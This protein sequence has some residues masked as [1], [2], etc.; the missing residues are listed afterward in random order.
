[1]RVSLPSTARRC[2]FRMA[3]TTCM[4]SC[5]LAEFCC[6]SAASAWAMASAASPVSLFGGIEVSVAGR[7]AGGLA[8]VA[9]YA[10]CAVDG[11]CAESPR[12]VR[13]GGRGDHGGHFVRRRS[14]PPCVWIATWCGLGTNLTAASR[15]SYADISRAGRRRTADSNAAAG[16][17]ATPPCLATSTQGHNGRQFTL[18]HGVDEPASRYR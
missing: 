8:V 16:N 13:S 15:S 17:D 10:P 2:A 9:E 5:E 6:A 3:E 12:P 18:L 7:L 1:M 4:S 14:D 11:S